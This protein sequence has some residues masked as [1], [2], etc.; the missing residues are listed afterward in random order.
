MKSGVPVLLSKIAR[1]RPLIVCFVGKGIWEIFRK[2]ISRL[3]D[4]A[5]PIDTS[6]TELTIKQETSEDAV[7]AVATV[8]RKG[9]TRKKTRTAPKSKAKKDVFSWG[10]QPFKCVHSFPAQGTR[11]TLFFVMPST[12]GRVISHQVNLISVLC[13]LVTLTR[14][15][16][17]SRQ[18]KVIRR[19]SG[20]S[21]SVQR[22]RNSNNEYGNHPTPKIGEER[23]AFVLS[24]GSV[25]VKIKILQ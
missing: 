6:G 13:F 2:E 14:I 11:E 8:A 4:T 19:A 24:S 15:N 20:P 23:M 12:S 17:A 16:V 3:I 9:S 10:I 25:V 5:S 18:S 21:R 22:R 1:L 7:E